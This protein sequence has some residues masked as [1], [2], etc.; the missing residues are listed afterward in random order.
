MGQNR[1]EQKQSSNG[2]SVCHQLPPL[3]AK[4]PWFVSQNTGSDEDSYRDQYFYTLHDPLT[5]YQ[6]QI[7]ELLGR[8]IRGYYHGWVI[9]SEHLQNVWS[10]W[11][12]VT[13]KLI[14]FPP[15]ILEDGDSEPIRECCLS[16]P[17]DD[18]S[19][20]LLLTRTNKPTFVFFRLEGKRKKL[21]WIK[22]SYA[23]QLKRITGEDGDFIH[24]LTCCNGKI[25]ALNTEYAFACFII[26]LDILVKDK[27]VLIKFLL[28]GAYP[29][30][31]WLRYDD[32]TYI[33][34]GYRTELFCFKVAFYENRLE[35]VCFFKL[36]MASVK[37]KDMERFKGLDMSCKSWHDMVDRFDDILMSMGLWEQLFDLQDAIFFLD[38][39]RDNL[40]Y[41]RPGIASEL[42]GYIHIRD[43]MDNIL[44]SYNVKENAI[45]LSSMPSFVL[46]TSNVSVWECRLEDDHGGAKCSL[47]IK[48]EENQIVARSFTDNEW[49]LLNLPFDILKLI[50]EYC[51]SVEYLNFRATCKRCEVAAPLI[52]WSNKTSLTRLQTYS[53]VSPWLMVVDKN[54]GII[55]FT[56]PMSGDNYFMKNLHVSLAYQ[57]F[58]CS[59]FGWLL[60]FSSDFQ[61]LVFFNPFTNDLRKLPEASYSFYTACFS[62]PPTSPDCMVVG[63][64][65][66]DECLVLIHYIARE[67]SWRTVRV[68]AEPDS[69]RFPTFSGQD[70][71]VLGGDGKLIGVKELGE[72]S[73]SSTFVESRGPVSCSTSPTRRYLMKCD[74][75]LLRVIVGK[76]GERVEVFKWDVSKGE[77]EKIDSLGNHMIYICDTT[78]LCIEAKTREMENKIYFPILHSKTKKIVFYSLKTCT[79]QTFNGE[80][81]QHFKGFF[82]TTYS[83]FPHAWIEPSWSICSIFITVVVRGGTI[84]WSG[85]EGPKVWNFRSL[86]IFSAFLRVF[87]IVYGEW[88]DAHM[89]VGYTDA[90]Y[91]V[92]SDAAALV[93]AGKSPYKR[94][95]YRY[96]PLIA[97]LLAPNSFI[98]QS[99]GKFIFSGSDLLVGYFIRVILKLRGVP[100]NLSIYSVIVW[101]FNPFTFTIGTRGNCEP[102]VCAIILW[103]IICLVR[104]NLFQGAVWYGLVVHM[105]IYPIIYALPIG[106]LLDPF[107]FQH[108]KKPSIIEWSSRHMKPGTNL[109]LTKSS[110]LNR[111]WVLFS[112]IFIRSRI[113]FGLVSATV[114]FFFTGLFFYLYEWE[115]LN[116]AL[117]YH[118]TRTN[119]RH[120]F[121]IYFYNMYLNYE[122]EFLV[123]EKLISFMPQ[124]I[125]Q[126]A[127]VSRF[128]QDFPFCFF[129][130]TVAFVAFNKFHTAC[131]K[132]DCRK[133][134]TECGSGIFGVLQE[135]QIQVL[136]VLIV[137]DLISFV[138]PVDI[139]ERRGSFCKESYRGSLYGT[140][141][142][143]GQ[144]NYRTESMCH[145]LA[146]IGHTWG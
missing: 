81:I 3:S 85:L 49:N 37:S 40:A 139:Y 21:R 69:V 15:L 51:V 46:P 30:P 103:I 76:F 135:T 24:N 67:S 142:A 62:A 2:G 112:S 72:E 50:M 146:N 115:F 87:L 127:L 10:L 5:K 1:M 129:L 111:L 80:N 48:Q 11:N 25:Y 99:W 123:I 66:G 23:N 61:S 119:P 4:Y 93:V 121:S 35:A 141:V 86:I 54:Q 95:T 96:S 20:V 131:N 31:S 59:R 13:S 122:L 53:L 47:D 137:F 105:R 36:D 106:I 107:H 97:F 74:Q 90:D 118:L 101:L 38:L 26:Q 41:Y 91:L 77:W 114:F 143:Y 144:I 110:N 56:D 124:L 52:Q 64:S 42:G 6:Y 70:I 39:G 94:S 44:Y 73:D 14:H 78:C 71:Y 57:M 33:M 75:D 138:S 136:A 16:A 126:V 18:P 88:Q 116:E 89:E 45:S 113:L 22:M 12:P 98:H 9:L 32:V 29:T 133:D 65:V 108:G 68:G 7:P 109:G 84:H 79:F 92:S 145:K 102:I 28:L 83:L 140:I 58:F 27:E 19:S 8:R 125:V 117:L 82:G 43:K 134:M 55:T 34:K 63:F 60:F 17:P 132:F 128:A 100:E 104:G 130:Q 120:S